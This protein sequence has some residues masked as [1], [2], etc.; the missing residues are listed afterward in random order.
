MNHPLLALPISITLILIC[1]AFGRKL[2]AFLRV[3]M[4]GALE[5][6]VFGVALGFGVVAYLILGIGLLGLLRA[7]AL[8]V[9]MIL[10]GVW[11]VR[12][13]VAIL[14]EL[15]QGARSWAGRRSDK[16]GQ[17]VLFAVAAA[18]ALV[19]L[20]SLAPPSALDWDALS[21]HLAVPKIYLRHHK[22]IYVPFTS[23]SNLPF[24]LEM[25]YT[26]GLSFGSIG[27]AKLFH[28]AT[29]AVSALAV[30]SL[31]RRHLNAGIGRLAALI[32]L[33]VPVVMWEAGNAY[34]DIAT[35]LYVTSA[36][37]A[38]LNWEQTRSGVWLTV[39]AIMCGFAL[40]TKVFA[41][42]PIAALC[43][44]ILFA[45]KDRGK[46]FRSA[47]LV[48][49]LALVVGSPWYIK[50]YVYTGNP[51]YPFLYSIF[52]GKYWSAS[53]AAAY[54]NSQSIF[55]M[56][57]GL[58]QLLLAP[59]NLTV[60]GNYF[61]DDPNN[62]KLFSFIGGVFLAFIPLGVLAG[63]RGKVAARLGLVCLAYGIAWFFLM[64]QVRYLI[65]VL[66]L[67]AVLAAWGLDAVNRTWKSTRYIANGFLAMCVLLSLFTGYLL[68]LDCAR[69]ALGLEPP[70]EYL[71]RTLDTYDAQAYAND[72]L[73]ADAKIVFFDEVRGFYL[74]REYMWGNPG[75]HE[76]TLWSSFHNG[77][78]MARYFR[79]KGFTYALVN[80]RLARYSGKDVLHV[81]Y[82]PEC[83]GKSLMR[84][85][86]SSRGVTLYELVAE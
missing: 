39:C 38:V 35:A 70:A 27:A 34:S 79:S 54:S 51:V 36:A 14:F 63:G 2:L 56:G 57:H 46:G 3:K 44:W 31:S 49:L 28:F 1:A 22:I 67:L 53:A 6:S 55:G 80:W 84:E 15:V 37:Y 16:V 10:I 83:I 72:S 74:D 71:S 26:L 17:V 29:Y 78:D 65:G 50:S 5:E 61:F 68:C 23:H 21:Y 18:G 62:P 12:E 4:E 77:S 48:A 33:T 58:K 86:Y 64:Q 20:R 73:P 59:W 82:L 40:S 52:G 9:L 24:L 43:L 7:E 41:V 42:V 81:R 19:L 75:H 25:L 30:Y 45:A 32:F 76:M 69:A 60:H 13:F 8:G 47:L 11:S 66:P 85:V